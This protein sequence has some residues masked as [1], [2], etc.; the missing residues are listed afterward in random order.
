MRNIIEAHPHRIRLMAYFVALMGAALL[1]DER[2]A[3]GV[4]GIGYGLLLAVSWVIPAG[5]WLPVAVGGVSLVGSALA[6]G[7]AGWL[8]FIMLG[9]FFMPAAPV[10]NRPLYTG[11]LAAGAVIIALLIQEIPL[12][13]LLVVAVGVGLSGFLPDR[14]TATPA[15]TPTAS[16][17]T[18]NEIDTRIDVAVDS[19]VQAA[20]AINQVVHQQNN[21]ATE[22]AQIISQMNNRMDG[23]LDQ[24][25]QIK[26][27]S[28]QVTETT[29]QTL[30][31][32]AEGAQ[33]LRGAINGLDG[34]QEQVVG[35]AE[36][37]VTL[38][39]LTRRVDQIISSVTEIATQS[40]LLA[41]NAS[42]EAARAG[43]QGRGFAVVADE[44]RSLSQQSS[45]AA[46]QVREI[47]AEIQQA[48]E[49]TRQATETGMN[50]VADGMR[51]T[52]QADDA[53]QALQAAVSDATAAMRDI[54]AV[55]TDQAD[56]LEDIGINMDRIDRITQGNLQS[57]QSVQTVSINLGRLADD[58]RESVAISKQAAMDS[59]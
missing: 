1:A 10:D 35:I 50:G 11:A 19:M 23:F 42:I 12:D 32:S 29:E 43:P 47:L 59:G 33:A 48:V 26:T 30:A 21:S 14:P 58:L 46:A 53:I 25:D 51:R 39:H 15:S 57:M 22:Q 55:I 27:R 16:V 49:E 17:Y 5:I 54:S 52:Q 8:I 56:G 20:Q 38:A 45:A 36:T 4:G 41:L 9:A 3:W 37:I 2:I 40:N 7:P 18:P 34:V 24:S 6:P 31:M 13:L 28:R 44:V